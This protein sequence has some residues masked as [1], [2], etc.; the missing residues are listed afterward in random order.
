[1]GL[2]DI[3][4]WVSSVLVVISLMLPR[5]L[6]F[7]LVNLI[8][9]ILA[10]VVNTVL[11]IWPFAAMN[12]A[13]AIINVYWLWKLNRERTVPGTYEVVEVGMDDNY[14]R[15][16]LAQQAPQIT[17]THPQFRAPAVPTSDHEAFLVTREA[18]TVGV[19]IVKNAG[20]GTGQ[21]VLDYVTERFRDFTPGMFV[22]RDSG[23]FAK[24]G[25]ARL[26][27]AD[28]VAVNEAFYRKAGFGNEGGRWVLPVASRVG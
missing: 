18:E 15:H 10:T 3:L 1:M 6:H 9:S 2:W 11:E 4:G 12:G 27:L 5:V 16:F 7:R 17:A 19:V 23:I 25:Y 22:Y 14:L 20:G 28:Q 24:L 8:G 13:I 26:E 21:I